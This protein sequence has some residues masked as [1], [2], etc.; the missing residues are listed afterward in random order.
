M[1][2]NP[3]FMGGIVTG[4]NRGLATIYGVVKSQVMMIALNSM[5]RTLGSRRHPRTVSEKSR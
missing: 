2:A 5:Y 1:A 4:Q 3:H